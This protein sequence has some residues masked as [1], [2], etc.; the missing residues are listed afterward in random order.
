MPAGFLP[1]GD[2]A[3]EVGTRIGAYE[4]VERIGEG[5]M[6]TVYRAEQSSPVR[7]T[8]ALKVVKLGMDTAEVITRFQARS[9]QV[10]SPRSTLV[11]RPKA[12]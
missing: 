12:K 9:W 4:L 6:G 5:G 8:V 10:V 7:R 2:G 1:D 3:T 11:P